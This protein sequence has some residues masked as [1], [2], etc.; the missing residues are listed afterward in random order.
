VAL[1]KRLY[2][3]SIFRREEFDDPEFPG[4]WSELLFS[5]RTGIA[6]YGV[7]DVNP[8]GIYQSMKDPS[9]KWTQVLDAKGPDGTRVQENAGVLNANNFV[10]T[11]NCKDPVTAIKWIDYWYATKD[12]YLL[13]T[14]GIEGETFK[15]VEGRPATLLAEAGEATKKKWETTRLPDGPIPHI[16]LEDENWANL[17]FPET[18]AFVKLAKPF[19]FNTS[20]LKDVIATPEESAVFTKYWDG[21]W[22]YQNEMISKFVTGKEPME[23]WDTFVA[24]LKKLG[25]EEVTSAKQAQ[26]DRATK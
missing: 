19:M 26:Y 20:A 8:N 16:S 18:A 24:Q 3:E 7:Y 11:K 15:M 10:V 13:S 23:N 25:A 4:K 12:G 22:G 14:W 2:T 17:K 9:A 1:L 5:G 21:L 6:S